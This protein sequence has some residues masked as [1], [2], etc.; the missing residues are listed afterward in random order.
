MIESLG[1]RL[2]VV[3]GRP[4]AAAP[5]PAAPARDA[6]RAG[7]QVEFVAY[8][9]DCV[10][11]GVVRL[12]SDRLTDMLNDHDEYQ[13]VDVLVEGLT[14]ERAVEVREVLVRRD[15]LLLVHAAG[16]RGNLDRRHRTRS[17]PVAIQMG[18]YHIRGYLHSL[19]GADPVQSIR[20]RKPMVP[21]TDAWIEFAAAAGRQRR[22]VGTVVVNREQIDWIVPAID[23]EVE[24]P[25]LPLSADKG[26]LLKDFTGALFEGL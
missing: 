5:P 8:G 9:E 1:R 13:L 10:L 16:P 12:A 7:Q 14:G 25:D 4:D 15:E 6:A 2:R 3:F 26:P 11:S 22:R 18:P 19:P 24:M 17:H 23:D 21:L 20:R